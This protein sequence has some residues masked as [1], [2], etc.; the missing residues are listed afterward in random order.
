M[1]YGGSCSIRDRRDAGCFTLLWAR[2]Y[3]FIVPLPCPSDLTNAPWSSEDVQLEEWTDEMD[4]A[5]T[6]Y[7]LPGLLTIPSE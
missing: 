4:V 2:C 1:A 3:S 6:R 5:T 7:Y